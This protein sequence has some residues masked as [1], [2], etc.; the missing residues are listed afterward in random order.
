ML[1]P[2]RPPLAELENPGEFIARHIGPTDDDE[3]RMLAA[4]GAPSRAAL[5]ERI[6]PASIARPQPMQLPPPASEA[7]ALAELKGI[8]AQNRVLRSF[9]GQGYHGT[10]TP[11]V[12]LRN[13]LENPAWYTASRFAALAGRD[14]EV[15]VAKPEPRLGVEP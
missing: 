8:A 9:I 11:G 15:R 14:L 4:V 10:H 13:V 5:I 12:I 7:Q 1:K 2:A 6:V 3:A